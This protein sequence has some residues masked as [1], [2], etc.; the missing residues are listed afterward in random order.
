MKDDIRIEALD[1]VIILKD[2]FG[3]G[4]TE[5]SL[6]NLSD[7]IAPNLDAIKS[8]SKND[9]YIVEVIYWGFVCVYWPMFTA[10]IFAGWLTDPSIL[11][12]QFP[13]LSPQQS[14]MV[15]RFK[16][17]EKITMEAS[18]I[19]KSIMEKIKVS[20]TSAILNINNYGTSKTRNLYIRGLFDLLELSETVDYC[21]AVIALDLQVVVLKKVYTQ[22]SLLKFE[23]VDPHIDRHQIGSISY[24]IKLPDGSSIVVTFY[25]NGNYVIR[26]NWRE[27]KGHSF[28]S[29]LKTVSL[30]VNPL[31]VRINNLKSINKF[32]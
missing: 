22:N 30:A 1:T 3:A 7:F 2:L 21:I 4:C 6:V 18:E 16:L 12:S 20:V 24:R 13:D 29:I 23:D 15:E 17:E 31:V 25:E 27:E 19:P 28:A 5:F 10:G 14:N 11:E 8:Q 32:P 9:K 26:T